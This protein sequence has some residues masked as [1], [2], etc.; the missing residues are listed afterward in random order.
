MKPKLDG[1]GEVFLKQQ[2]IAAV[3]YS[4][5]PLSGQARTVMVGM[6]GVTEGPFDLGAQNMSMTLRTE[7]G[8]LVDFFVTRMVIGPLGAQIEIKTS[9]PL[10]DQ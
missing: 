7:D 10:R 1:K 9:S 8:S 3:S 5:R 2:R 6:L 4:L